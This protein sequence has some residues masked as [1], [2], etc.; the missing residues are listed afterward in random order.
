LAASLLVV[1]LAAI[2]SAAVLP[3]LLEDDKLHAMS[4]GRLYPYGSENVSNEG[5]EDVLLARRDAAHYNPSPA[6]VNYYAAVHAVKNYAKQ[7]MN[8]DAVQSPGHMIVG[9][10]GD[11]V[12]FKQSYG[13]ASISPYRKA[14][15]NTIW[16]LGSIGKSFTAVLI[17]MLVDENKLAWNT[18]IVDVLPGFA[19]NNSA[20]TNLLTIRDFL[21]MS[22]GIPRNDFAWVIGRT[23]IGAS[24]LA[25]K[26]AALVP[27]AEPRTRFWYNSL[28]YNFLGRIIELKWNMT[29]AQAVQT[30]LFA[31]LGM[32]GSAAT[33]AEAML[34]GKYAYPHVVSATTSEAINVQPLDVN[35]L[36]VD[37]V[38]PAGS[39]S[40]TAADEAKWLSAVLSPTYKGLVSAA[41]GVYL[42]KANIQSLYGRDGSPTF[43]TM[44]WFN[45]VGGRLELQFYA[46]GNGY[47]H[48][49][50][51]DRPVI[52]H[53]GGTLGHSSWTLAFP[54]DNLAFTIVANMDSVSSSAQYMFDWAIF[55]YDKFMGFHT[56]TVKT[57]EICQ[58]FNLKA[59]GSE[60]PL[61]AYVDNS[62]ITD[63][64]LTDVFTPAYV[65][66]VV[67]TYRN[68]FYGDM[69]VSAVPGSTNTKIAF[70]LGLM[71]GQLMESALVGGKNWLSSPNFFQ[72]QLFG[73]PFSAF[74][75]V[76]GQAGRVTLGLEAPAA[77]PVF[78]RI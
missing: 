70:H 76:T 48:G 41:T 67:G 40:V 43:T 73:G 56:N 16:P 15:D 54:D 75:P 10:Q 33:H 12:L 22:S 3:D 14:R 42:R 44:N 60:G 31:P 62:Y 51:R 27:G 17:G 53:N 66:S 55:A 58:R 7:M 13:K 38:A 6:P 50:Y 23:A 4:L 36:T 28:T 26:F 68:E 59:T 2:T 63:F 30:K 39:I 9:V 34:T 49:Y 78:L 65:N 77:A 71:H 5:E 21:S 37:T 19:T 24:A 29:Y 20:L 72:V 46:Y 57:A 61:L 47:L 69:I 18:R 8:C 74:D 35:V 64:N 32:T 45:D 52:A 11:T 25:P 1:C